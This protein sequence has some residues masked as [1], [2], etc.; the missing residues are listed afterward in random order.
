VHNLA[1]ISF[2]FEVQ[3][4]SNFYFYF[5]L[6]LSKWFEVGLATLYVVLA[7]LLLIHS[8]HCMVLY[9]HDLP[10]LMIQLYVEVLS[11]VERE[12]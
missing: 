2:H 5:S 7:V 12:T 9:T 10:P 1:N 3:L 11:V 6:F 8:V 4:G